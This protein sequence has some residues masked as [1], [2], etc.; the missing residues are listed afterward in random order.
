MDIATLF[1]KFALALGLGLLVGMQRE[2]SSS[3]L[4]GFRTF[5]LVTMLGTLC[6]L[7]SIA[8]G[9]PVIAAGL[10][11]LVAL[12][13]ISNV[14]KLRAGEIDPGMTTEVAVL[15]M[16]ALG[17][18]LVTGPAA[19]SV[20]LGATVT[21]LLHLKSEL[22]GLAKRIGAR[23]FHAIMLF[24][25]I[26][27]VILP[28]LPDATFGPYQ[29]LNPRRIWWMV[30]LIT[31][32]S[33][34]GYLIYKAFDQTTGA[35][36]G[37]ILGGLISSTAT[38]VSYARRSKEQAG[39]E[40]PAALVI[41]LA[42]A[43][44]FAR[45][46]VT[47]AVAAPAHFQGIAPSVSIMLVLMAVLSFCLWWRTRGDQSKLPEQSNPTELKS[48]IVFAALFAVVLLAVAAAKDLFGDRGLYPV[49]ILSGLTDMDAI[50]LSSAE[51]A[52]DGR[53][54]TLTAARLI[55]MA[56]LANMVFKAG[57]VAALGSRAL[58][59]RI[60]IVFS[61]ALIGGGLLLWWM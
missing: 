39:S 20:V 34:G 26:A 37:G 42:G 22:H 41:V 32:I 6:G 47:I 4:A 36:A 27:L 16:F 49:A 50:T 43:V 12:V 54:D 35:V 45:V 56:S 60:A 15:M 59:L 21:L 9:W 14:A 28:V 30:V 24:V 13:V 57:M 48:A 18:Y 23:D 38:T 2:R 5:P 8:H 25:A 52:R 3:S 11:A 40:G 58:F 46:L 53:V 33:L 55:I 7:L 61:A 44:V 31:G 29:V 51:M 10:I 1:Q 17:A 19:V